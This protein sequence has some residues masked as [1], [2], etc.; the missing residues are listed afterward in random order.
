MRKGLVGAAALLVVVCSASA[1][2]AF[3]RSSYDRASMGGDIVVAEGETSSDVACAF[4]SV[5]I[6][7]SVKGDV[8]VLFGSVTVDD[9]QSVSGDVAILGGD[10]NLK[11]GSRVGGDVAIAAGQANVAQGATI[12]GS[13]SVLPGKLWLLVPFAPLLILIGIV[14]L[15]VW[16]IRRNRYPPPVYPV[17][18]P[19]PGGRR[20]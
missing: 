9:G 13:Q 12:H 4:C 6:H 11:E 20:V 1:V 16:M 14:W 19:G 10:L 3:A 5:H 18:P 7:G 17:Y 8:A 15:I 2:P